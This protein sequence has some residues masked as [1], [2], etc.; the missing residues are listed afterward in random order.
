MP[1]V[2][3]A[4]LRVLGV[5]ALLLTA[6]PVPDASERCSPSPSLGSYGSSRRERRPER[7]SRAFR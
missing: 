7:S 5:T 3:V 1:K 2:S 4:I 6:A